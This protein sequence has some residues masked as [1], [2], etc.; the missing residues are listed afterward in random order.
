MTPEQ[1]ADIHRAAFHADRAWSAEEFA[2]MIADPATTILSE[3]DAFLLFRR[4][5]DEAELLTLAVAPERRRQGAATRLI[6]R[7]IAICEDSRVARIFLEVAADNAAAISLYRGAGFA[8]V[9]ERVDYYR[10]SAGKS[11]TALVMS[12]KV[13]KP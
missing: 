9:G 10:R 3:E 13:M 12:R 1:L 2:G 11:V 5:A 4:A 7:M 6:E 8:Q